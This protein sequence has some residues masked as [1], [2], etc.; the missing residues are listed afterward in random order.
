M[1]PQNA[2]ANTQARV[3]DKAIFFPVTGVVIGV[4]FPNDPP[5]SGQGGAVFPRREITYD[6]QLDYA[7]LP[8]LLNVPLAL[9]LHGIEDDAAEVLLVPARLILPQGA[10]DPATHGPARDTDGDQ[11]LVQFIGGDASNPIITNV[12]NHSQRG[13]QDPGLDPR[14]RN[15][16][17]LL[18]PGPKGDPGYVFG[19]GFAGSSAVSLGAILGNRWMHT[20][21]NGTHMALDANGDVFINFKAHPDPSKNL[22]A[23][24]VYKRFVIQVEG[25]DLFRVENTAA[26]PKVTVGKVYADI[27]WQTGDGSM[28]VAIAQHLSTFYTTVLKP[29]L[30]QHQHPTGTGLSGFPTTL[31]PTFPANI[32]S[33]KVLIPDG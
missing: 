13:R 1:Y 3:S 9:G 21:V 7:G 6:V 29:M 32:T 20:S 16:L 26:G 31:T 30:D 2:I 33:T 19:T 18:T 25:E 4:N 23:G 28:S 17:E 8:P 24:A 22:P 10:Y 5:T 12:L 15:S 14:Y 27:V 11:V